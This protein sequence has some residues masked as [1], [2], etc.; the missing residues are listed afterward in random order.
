VAIVRRSYIQ[1]LPG[2]KKNLGRPV[3]FR[4]LAEE[5]AFFLAFAADAPLFS[6]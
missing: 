3:Q 5:S 6:G 2:G 4:R 1:P